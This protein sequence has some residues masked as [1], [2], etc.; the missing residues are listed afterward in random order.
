MSQTP[1]TL[2]RLSRPSSTVVKQYN[3]ES[4]DEV[5]VNVLKRLGIIVLHDLPTFISYHPAFMGT[6]VNSP[7]VQGVVKAMMTMNSTLPPGRFT[8][9]LQRDLST[10][11]KLTLRSFLANISHYQ[12]EKEGYR[13]FLCSLPIFETLSKTFVSKNDGLSA[14]PVEAL[15]VPPPQDLIDISNDDSWTLAQILNVR[16]LQPVEV[17]CEIIFPGIHEG[18]YDEDQIDEVMLYVFERFTHEIRKNANFKWQVQALAFVPKQT[19]RVRASDV[20]DPRN[21]TLKKIFAQEDVFPEGEIYTDPATLV[22]LEAL[23]MK[24]ESNISAR[25]LFYSVRQVNRISHHQTAREKSKAILHH[26]NSHPKKL[27]ETVD[28]TELGL[29]LMNI[30][31]VPRL[32][33][34]EPGFPPSLPWWK[35]EKAEE[36]FFKPTELKSPTL[37]NLIGSVRPVVELE[38]LEKVFEYYGW[39]KL[40]DVFDVAL[41]LRNVISSYSKDEKPYYMVIL[42]EIYSYLSRANYKALSMAFQQTDVVNWV[43][44]GDGFSSPNQI[45]SGKLRIDLTPYIRPLPSEMMKFTLLFERF[46]VKTHTDPNVLLQVLYAIKEKYDAEMPPSSTYEVHHDLQLSV[47]ILNELAREELL[48]DIQER[49]VIPV[50]IE[51][52]KHVLLE[53]V[54]RCMYSENSEWLITDGEDEDMEYFYVHPDVPNRTAQRLG[55]PSLTNR[56]LEP[57][58]LFIGEE[59]GQEEKLTTRLSRLLDDYTDGFAVPKELIQNADDAGATEVKFLYDERTNEDA[60]TCLIDEGMKGCQGRALWVYNDATFKDED[61]VNITKLNE[62][63]K[64]NDTTKIGRFGLGFNAVYNLTDVPMFVS[65]NY[66]AIFDPHT[67]FLGKAIKN[68]RRP[69][70]KINLNKDVSRLKKFK[71]QLKPFNGIFGCDLHLAL[72]E[73]LDLL[74]FTHEQI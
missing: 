25:D 65:K 71:N 39:Q 20:F 28:G 7:T 52:N 46:G 40:P 9:I 22:T 69:G 50:Y 47:G 67:S 58:E 2:T 6:Y 19:E 64:A 49:I 43:W 53:P 41:Q 73:K 74:T 15:P 61:F 10:T 4:I 27:K 12:I 23:G 17:L 8:E 37:V 60:I 26:L 3:E 14:A 30:Q 1:V 68:I 21:T 16:I 31:W 11:E 51:D 32:K 42:N 55:V 5:L 45:L 48:P 35:T 59:F 24:N 38:Q 29:L 72:H 70:M 63:T 54:E 13:V 34:K 36:S 33:Q 66:L 62:A 57:E 18:D 44:N 56:M